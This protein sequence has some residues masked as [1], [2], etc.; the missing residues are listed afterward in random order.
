M[1]SAAEA[2]GSTTQGSKKQRA[3]GLT[4]RARLRDSKA[5]VLRNDMP[6]RHT[7]PFHGYDPSNS[8][9]CT[10]PLFFFQ[11]EK[12]HEITGWGRRRAVCSEGVRQ[13]VS[14]QSRR[15]DELPAIVHVHY[16]VLNITRMSNGK[17]HVR[18]LYKWTLFTEGYGTILEKMETTVFQKKFITVTYWRANRP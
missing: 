16:T 9:R 11:N 3:A 1:Q 5:P 14:I 4:K 8:P 18:N 12:S 17:T 2:T 6:W 15:A 13:S 10:A 7:S